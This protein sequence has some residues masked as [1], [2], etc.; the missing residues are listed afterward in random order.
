MKKYRHGYVPCI[1]FSKH[2]LFPTDDSLRQNSYRI[3]FYFFMIG[4]ERN[5]LQLFYNRNLQFMLQ[6]RR[7]YKPFFKFTVW[8]GNLQ[9]RRQQKTS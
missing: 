9:D 8:K 3:G 1:G 7:G 5:T 6:W 4:S 2:T